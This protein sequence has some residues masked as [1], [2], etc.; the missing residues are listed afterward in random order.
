MT[1]LDKIINRIL[2][3]AKEEARLTLENAQNDC[4]RAA[5]DFA[6]RAEDEADSIALRA[7]AAA[8]ELI[9]N[10]KREADELR[11]KKIAE[12]KKALV[13]EAFALAK[14]ELR[15][16]EFGKYR[17]LLTALLTSKLL[18]L[19]HKREAAL[20]RGEEVADVAE[21][22]VVMNEADRNAWGEGVVRAARCAA[23]RH[24]GAARVDRVHLAEETADIDGG[25]LLF[26]DSVLHDLS[27][28]ALLHTLRQ[29]I[30]PRVTAMLFPEGQ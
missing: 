30:E 24:M 27:L 8:E 5:E 9:E 18:D 22:R 21:Y 28:E 17:E 2:A 4:K 29:E 16:T 1:G 19:T 6:A 3:D 12:T 26:C 23:Y 20:A 14:K 25:L 13:D 10:A 15:K 11:D 7:G